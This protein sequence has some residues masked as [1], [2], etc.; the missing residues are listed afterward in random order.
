[1]NWLLCSKSRR[2]S[3]NEIKEK[4]EKKQ[5]DL[6]KNRPSRRTCSTW[7]KS[8]KS[9]FFLSLNAVIGRQDSRNAAVIAHLR[10]SQLQNRGPYAACPVASHLRC[11]A[12][13]RS[14]LDLLP[15]STTPTRTTGFSSY[16]CIFVF[17]PLLVPLAG[18]FG[19]IAFQYAPGMF[20]CLG[21]R[22]GG[23]RAAR[24]PRCRSKSVG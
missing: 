7:P 4:T 9:V 23:E 18:P 16:R 21:G 17:P 2:H 11:R 3:L 22:I 14:R 15:Q 24:G 12:C 6:Q 1:M 8:G 13:S 20:R 10:G 5:K 19:S